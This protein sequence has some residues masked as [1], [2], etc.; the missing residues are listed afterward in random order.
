MVTNDK[1]QI[2]VLEG[3]W[4]TPAPAEEKPQL[5]GSKCFNCGEII[6]PSNTVCVN[7]QYQT[8][9]QIKLSRRGKI[10][11]LSTVMLAP[12]KYY[13]GQVPYAIGYVELPDGVRILT[14][15]SGN[16][17]FLK[18]GMDVELVIEK[19]HENEEGD[20]IMGFK[21]KAIEA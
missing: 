10:F 1:K 6:F 8:M 15:F 20:E 9:E 21:F 17:D 13:T 7:C 5:V 18:I 2:P 11:S 4:T 19:L 3:L 12:P 16:P 14:S